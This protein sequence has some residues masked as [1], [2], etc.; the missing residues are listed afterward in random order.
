MEYVLTI[1]RWGSGAITAVGVSAT[2][3]G[4]VTCDD[5]IPGSQDG[6][7]RGDRRVAQP[8]K[9]AGIRRAGMAAP[10]GG[11]DQLASARGLVD[12]RTPTA[13]GRT[14]LILPR[15]DDRS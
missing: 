14:R 12:G 15:R 7:P 8:I 1:W 11:L 10:V 3:A 5:G 13:E 9:S 6:V 2:K 4:L